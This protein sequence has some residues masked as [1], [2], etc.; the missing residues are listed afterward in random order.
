MNWDNMTP[1]VRAVTRE[2]SDQSLL[3]FSRSMFR[4]QD[5]GKFM[6]NWHHRLICDEL[7]KVE[8]GETT[9]LIINVS[10]GGSKTHLV[11]ICF[12]ARGMAREKK[13]RFL[14]VSY[15]NDLVQLNSTQVRDIVLSPEFQDMW[16]T[17]IAQDSNDKKLWQVLS[18]KGKK[19]GAYRAVSNGGGITGFRAG[20][21]AADSYYGSLI[22]DDPNKPGD[23]L[24]ERKRN[25][26]NQI[27]DNI[28]TRLGNTGKTPIILIQQRLH[29]EDATG[30]RIKNMTCLEDGG[31]YKIWQTKNNPKA[32]KWKQIIIPALIDDQYTQSL[33]EKYRK[34]VTGMMYGVDDLGRYSYW[35]EKEPLHEMLEREASTPYLFKAQYQQKPEALGGKVFPE[36]VWEYYNRANAPKFAWR[37]ITADTA[38]KQNEWNDFSVFAIWGVADGKIYLIDY[39]RGKWAAPQ[40]KVKFLQ[41]IATHNCKDSYPRNRYGVLRMAAVEDK[42]SGT[43]LIQETRHA[44]PVPVVPK[45][46]HPLGKWAHAQDTLPSMANDK[47]AGRV[48]LPEDMDQNKLSVWVVEHAEFTIDDTHDHDDTVDNTM[49][50]VDIGIRGELLNS[51]SNASTVSAGA[52][53]HTHDF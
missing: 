48:F 36:T 40:L 13:A 51:G 46:S 33:P 29:P 25:N 39:I 35:P 43:G 7:E 31:W 41:F 50:A 21:L 17:K 27:F 15:S 20:R 24:T 10:P 18:E 37:F 11:S 38:Q 19:A 5:G 53:T 1:V 34:Y 32:R 9:N 45:Q 14:S 22:L 2:L 23:M 8:A 28:N 6:V 44:A 52:D 47:M 3:L 12:P 16:P 30:F 49:M 4:F 26:S 42:V